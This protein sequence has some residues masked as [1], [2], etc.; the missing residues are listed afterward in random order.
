MAAKERKGNIGDPWTPIDLGKESAAD[1]TAPNYRVMSGVLFDRNRWL[2]PLLL[3][4]H[5]G[6]DQIPMTARFD[7]V[8]RGQGTTEGH[9]FREVRFEKERHVRLFQSDEGRDRLA[10]ISKDMIEE[11]ATLRNKV[12]KIP[13][14]TLIQAGDATVDFRDK[15]ANAWAQPWLDQ[16][17]QAIE[18]VF[19]DH[20][21]ARAEQERAADQA[22]VRFL[23]TTAER[24]FHWASAA[25]PIAGARRLKAIAVAEEKLGG[26]FYASFKGYL[27]QPEQEAADG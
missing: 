11:A 5:E 9:H 6:I 12:L 3:D 22:W 1:N 23:R 21:F 26:L 19:F 16:V 13:L 2:R 18:S 25:V 10:K 17:D 15:M 4:W 8:V 27:V 20:L 14:L 24:V 7:V